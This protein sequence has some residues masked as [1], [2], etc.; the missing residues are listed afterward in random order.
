MSFAV[1]PGQAVALIGP[2]GAGKSTLLK[3]ILGTVPQV[4]GSAKVLGVPLGKRRTRRQD[5]QIGYLAQHRELDAEFPVTLEQVVLMGRYRALGPFGLLTRADRAA[6]AHAIETVGLTSE[7]RSHFGSL[8]GGQQQRGF[9]A[10]AI[11]SGPHLLLLDEP[12]NGLD[13][14]NRE[15]LITTI[16]ALK[17]QGVS[18]IVSTHDFSLARSVAESVV[19]LKSKQLAFGACTDVLLA[20]HPV[21]EHAHGGT[22]DDRAHPDGFVSES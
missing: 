12:F 4:A 11:A 16:H 22:E 15:A 1:N 8:S 2:N 17:A 5:S 7:A 21:L 3:G 20:E 18:V 19:L 9:L 6:A 14:D 13:H 10:R